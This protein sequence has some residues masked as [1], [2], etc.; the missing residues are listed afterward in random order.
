MAGLYE[1]KIDLSSLRGRAFM[2]G[3]KELM[4]KIAI[5]TGG[6]AISAAPLRWRWRKAARLLW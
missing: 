4:G 1:G 2:N 3:T 6:G 5:V